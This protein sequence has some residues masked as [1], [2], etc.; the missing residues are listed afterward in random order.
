MASESIRKVDDLYLRDCA[1]NQAADTSIKS[2]GDVFRLGKW[3]VERDLN[4]LRDG[5]HS[6][7]LSPLSMDILAYLAHPPGR[8]VSAEELVRE[9]W[10]GRI[11]SDNPVYKIIAKLRRALCDDAEH[12]RYIETVRKRGYRLVAPVSEPVPL[13]SRSH[14]SGVSRRKTDMLSRM[15]VIL[16]VCAIGEHADEEHYGNG[17][18][19]EFMIE[20]ARF[21]DIRVVSMCDKDTDPD[22]ALQA[23]V[24]MKGSRVRITARLTRRSDGVQLWAGAF[25]RNCADRLDGQ[26]SVAREVAHSVNNAS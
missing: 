14:G 23:S 20:L 16:P 5:D 8:V 17:L 18:A 4:R 2:N 19:E 21:N 10:G 24:R 9:L 7:Q 25:E 3:V 26:I 1:S 12:P 11:V 13:D 22:L 6:V 15:V